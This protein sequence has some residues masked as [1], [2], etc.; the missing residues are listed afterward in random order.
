MS[1]DCFSE[2][3]QSSQ[4]EASHRASAIETWRKP[5][6]FFMEGVGELTHVLQLLDLRG[7]RTGHARNGVIR[8]A[9]QG[10]RQMRP[11]RGDGNCWYRALIV[12][13]LE[14]LLIGYLEET[15]NT[16]TEC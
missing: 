3:G 10:V 12:G 16:D 1:T 5:R 4:M 14:L 8:L 7:F 9:E 13:I 11:V 2:L 6:W 15:R